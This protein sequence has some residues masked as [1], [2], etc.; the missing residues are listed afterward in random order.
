MIFDATAWNRADATAWNRAD[1]ALF[2][3]SVALRPSP[4]DPALRR[5]SRIADHSVLW[6]GC[7]AL[8]IAAGGSARRGAVRGLLSVAASSA[9]A[10]G[11]LK[12]L[13]PRRRPPARVE[14]H[15]RRRMVPMPTSSSF[16]SGHAASAAAFVTGLALES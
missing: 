15:F 12:P 2:E 1:R 3:R 8:C 9:L 11:V 13:L 14:P 10:N 5:L 7:A 4:T 6:L 16:P